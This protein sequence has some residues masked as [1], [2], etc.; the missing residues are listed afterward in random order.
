MLPAVSNSATQ[1]AL[2]ISAFSALNSETSFIKLFVNADLPAIRF[3]NC[4]NM[5][6]PLFAIYL[7]FD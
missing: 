6:Y 7:N 5:S 2:L 4:E 3:N 1:R